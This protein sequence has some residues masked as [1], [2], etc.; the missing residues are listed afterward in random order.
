MTRKPI[1]SVIPQMPIGKPLRTMNAIHEDWKPGDIC[2]IYDPVY[3]KCRRQAEVMEKYDATR[4]GYNGGEHYIV[5]FPA[6]GGGRWLDL[7]AY[8][9]MFKTETDDD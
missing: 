4:F 3:M 2:W 8:P 5:E 6:R 1:P 9:E 7:V